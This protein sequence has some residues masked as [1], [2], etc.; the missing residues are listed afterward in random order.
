MTTEIL[1]CNTLRSYN[2]PQIYRFIMP[3]KILE[4]QDEVQREETQEPQSFHNGNGADGNKNNLNR[5][6]NLA[7]RETTRISQI[8]RRTIPTHLRTPNL[9]TDSAGVEAEESNRYPMEAEVLAELP[10]ELPDPLESDLRGVVEV[11]HHDGAVTPLEELQH[12][13]AADVPGTAR[14][15]NVPRR[16][17][18][19][20]HRIGSGAAKV[21]GGTVEIWRGEGGASAGTRGIWIQGRRRKAYVPAMVR[22]LSVNTPSFF[23]FFFLPSAKRLFHVDCRSADCLRGARR[24]ESAE[25]YSSVLVRGRRMGGAAPFS[26]SEPSRKQL[27]QRRMVTRV[28]KC[29][30]DP[31]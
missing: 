31:Y 29:F 11:V 23:Y 24:L 18:R 4:T 6:V 28:A 21:N 3:G 12:R 2:P 5:E 30:P 22:A 19:R 15:Q 13:M 16:G 27:P 20:R 7:N 25:T 8:S 9:I 26:C 14:H 17:R 1:N 10:G